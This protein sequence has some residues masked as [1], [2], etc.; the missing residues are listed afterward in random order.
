MKLIFTRFIIIITSPQGEEDQGKL[1]P[2][3]IRNAEHL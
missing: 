3:T 1:I 2:G